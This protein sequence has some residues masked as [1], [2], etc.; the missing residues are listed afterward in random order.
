MK[1][2][3]THTPRGKDIKNSLGIKE[4]ILINGGRA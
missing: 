2:K 4:E 3:D 1:A